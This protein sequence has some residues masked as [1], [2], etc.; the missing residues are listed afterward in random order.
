[1][2]K[3][4]RLEAP[5]QIKSVNNDGE[6]SAY[7]S[8]FGVKDSYN[9]IVVKGAF[10]KSLAELHSK[11]RQPAMLWQHK[12]DE[13]IGIYTKVEEDDHGLYVEGRLLIDEDPVAKRAHGHMKAK[14]VSGMSIG[15][16]LN[17]YEYD[18]DKAAWMLKEIELVEISLVTVPSNDQ[19]RVEEVKSALRAGGL[20]VQKNLERILRDVG[21]S[22][23]AA[24]AF[25]SGGYGA[26][27]GCDDPAL[28]SGCDDQSSNELIGIID[29]YFS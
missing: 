19:A 29:K 2:M 27:K 20:P 23:K 13:P 24:R 11:G 16:Y 5:L 12:M 18:E 25:M 4:N 3:K 28:K 8:V 6:F 1:M 14:S 26:L 15:Y 9:D 10:L 21:F 17:D 22:K 7:G